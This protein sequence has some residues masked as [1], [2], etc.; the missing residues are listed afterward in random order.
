GTKTKPLAVELLAL[1]IAARMLALDPE[2]PDAPRLLELAIDR[3]DDP[4]DPAAFPDHPQW[5]EDQ[6]RDAVRAS[7]GAVAWQLIDSV[8]DLRV[9]PEAGDLLVA[10]LSDRTSTMPDRPPG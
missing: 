5:S 4:A 9:R 8:E 2:H 3:M 10:I 6:R 1:N 7:F